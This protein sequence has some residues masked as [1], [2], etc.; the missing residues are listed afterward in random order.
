MK[1]SK[2]PKNKSLII[3]PVI[4]VKIYRIESFFGLFVSLVIGLKI[5]SI[6]NGKISLS[7]QISDGIL[8]TEIKRTNGYDVIIVDNF[9]YLYHQI[10]IDLIM[11]ISIFYRLWLFV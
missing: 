4:R 7:Q 10:P 11:I 5:F 9:F 2:D 8:I 3:K 1:N 6:L